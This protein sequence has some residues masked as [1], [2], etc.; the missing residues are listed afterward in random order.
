[1]N[2]LLANADFIRYADERL[3]KELAKDD[4][5][6]ATTLVGNDVI[7]YALLRG[8]EE[9]AAAATIGNVYTVTDLETLGTANNAFLQGLVADLALCYLFE[10]RGGDVPESVKAKANR[11]AGI[12]N[13][14]RDG[15]RVFAITSN[16]DAGVAQLSIVN[17][18][19]RQQLGMTAD[20]AFFPARQTRP[21]Q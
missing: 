8:G 12:L 20:D 18:L 13:D 19:V 9:I 4:N 14:I 16:R 6:D 2:Q 10:R 7:T 17:S 15:K 5:T 3:L 11:A 1:M 21:Y